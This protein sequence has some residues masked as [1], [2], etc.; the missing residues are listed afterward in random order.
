MPG[1]LKNSVA[2]LIVFD[3]SSNNPCDSGEASFEQLN[4]WIDMV[5]EVRGNE[6]KMYLIAN[7]RDLKEA[8]K[9]ELEQIVEFAN[10]E[11]LKFY[12]VSAKDGDGVA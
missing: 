12:E 6:A 5:K 8:R 4:S 2:V 7:K 3:V 9:V 10:R 11:G 1:Y